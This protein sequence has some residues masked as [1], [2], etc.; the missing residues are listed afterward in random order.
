MIKKLHQ[1]PGK[2]FV[3]MLFSYFAGYFKKSSIAAL[4]ETSINKS[5]NLPRAKLAL[6][7]I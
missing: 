3:R 1:F 6:N 5:L 7:I 4:L 2:I